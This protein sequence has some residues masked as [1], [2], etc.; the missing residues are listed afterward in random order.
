MELV[1]NLFI[2]LL[3]TVFLTFLIYQPFK[4]KKEIDDE[5]RRLYSEFLDK[6]VKD[7]AKREE[8]LELVKSFKNL[9]E[10]EAEK[11]RKDFITKFLEQK[12]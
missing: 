5:K 8:Y 2:I 9:D 12:H 7:E 10:R 11:L 4:K 1:L 6:L 3:I